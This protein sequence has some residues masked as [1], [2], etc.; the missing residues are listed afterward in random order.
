NCNPCQT[1]V[2]TKSKLGSDGDP[3]SNSTLYRSLAGTL[4]YLTFTRPDLFYVVQKAGCPITRWSTSSYCVFLGDNLLSWSIK[5]HVILSRSS[6][7]AE[8]HGV[9]NVVAET[10]WLQNLL[11]ELHASLATATIV[12]RDNVSAVYLSTNPVQHHRTKHIEIYIHF[13]RDY[14][15]SGQVRVLHVPSRF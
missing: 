6:E 5:R 4:Q 9:M 8:Y 10:A 13:V 14:V 2:D 15:A 12:Y 1:H 11:L 3:V 7:E